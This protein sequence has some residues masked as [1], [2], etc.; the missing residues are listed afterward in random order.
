MDAD[1]PLSA[2]YSMS[3][4]G[5]SNADAE[6]RADI[7]A[8]RAETD[9]GKRAAL[10]HKVV[11]YAREKAY[12][13]WLILLNDIYGTSDRLVWEPRT[14]AKLLVKEMSVTK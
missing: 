11:R 5:S 6:M 9:T 12:L 4:P 1:R 7:D 13:A 10:Y 2:Y 8:A 3:G 14:D